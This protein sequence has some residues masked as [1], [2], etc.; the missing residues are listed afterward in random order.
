MKI[1]YISASILPS[2]YANSVHVMKM[3]QALAKNGHQV[4]LFGI[5]GSIEEEDTYEYYNV[6]PVFDLKLI[7]P[8]RLAILRKMKAILDLSREYDLIYTRYTIAAFLVSYLLGRQV[9]YEYHGIMESVINRWLEQLLSRKKNVRHVFITESLRKA[10]EQMNPT[11]NDKDCLVLAD[12]ADQPEL[13]MRASHRKPMTC[14]YIGSFQKGKG[15]ELILEI[16]AACREMQFHIVGGKKEEIEAFQEQ[17]PGD[18]I[19]WHGFVRQKE[20]MKILYEDIDIALLPNQRN[21]MV[22]KKGMTDIGAY[23]S[24][25]KLFEYMSYGKA[26][27]ASRLPVLQEVICDGRNALLADCGDVQE[28][29]T[30]IGRL[31]Q[32]ETLFETI[33]MH[34]YEDFIKKYTWESRAKRAVEG[35]LEIRKKRRK[36]R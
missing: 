24:P 32:D 7:R 16:A 21:M 30:A 4:T 1:L 2:Q 10:Y 15:V 14:G 20:A 18:N 23:T 17:Y 31:Q 19:I 25:M 26:I 36:P 12:C 6:D 22:G 29:I 35:L 33:R 28:W 34:A 9:I 11:L 13:P 8:G 5:Q 3:S 27:V